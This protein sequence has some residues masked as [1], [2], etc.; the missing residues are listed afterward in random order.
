MIGA[1]RK[2]EEQVSSADKA[3]RAL[4]DLAATA[5]WE[6]IAIERDLLNV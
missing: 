1:R 2:C 3:M 4:I 6:F 5:A